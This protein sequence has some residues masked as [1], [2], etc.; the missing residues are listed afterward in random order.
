LDKEDNILEGNRTFEDL[1][2]WIVSRDLRIELEQ[3]AGE[4]PEIEKFSLRSQITR[5][6]R[7]V[8]NNIA[9]GYGRYHFQENI[10]FCR[11]S[12]GSIYETIDHIIIANDNNYI[13][14][15][16]CEEMKTKCYELVKLINGYIRYLKKQKTEFSKHE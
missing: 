6:A 13:S 12:R 9:E 3:M 7:S 14:N 4:F 10:Q 15:E 16:K 11:Q 5:S 8:T 1:N 2:V